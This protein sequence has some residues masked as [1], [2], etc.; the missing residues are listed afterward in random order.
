MKKIA[1]VLF[2]L[3][4]MVSIFLFSSCEYKVPKGPVFIE[5]INYQYLVIK[6]VNLDKKNSDNP[7]AI[8]LEN[9][10]DHYNE[11]YFW[12]KKDSSGYK[13][14]TLSW[15]N[16]HVLSENF[17]YIILDTIHNNIN[18]PR[19]FKS[20]NTEAIFFHNSL[21]KAYINPGKIFKMTFYLKYY[22]DTWG[23]FLTK[24]DQGLLIKYNPKNKTIEKITAPTLKI[25]KFDWIPVFLLLLFIMISVLINIKKKYHLWI[26]IKTLLFTAIFIGIGYPI[27]L[28]NIFEPIISIIIF[29]GCL[30]CLGPLIFRIKFHRQ[31]Q[32]AILNTII[33]GLVLWALTGQFTV[34]VISMSLISLAFFIPK[35]IKKL[36]TSFYTKKIKK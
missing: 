21:T 11:N 35:F 36:T 19:I 1:N 24:Y 29:A 28:I 9:R 22:Y 34:L 12:I 5:S 3:L 32:Y 7:Q 18:S 2:G 30:A 23:I 8:F 20:R 31:Y 14:I 17:A 10:S 4:F 26:L 16:E 27:Y 6:Q 25:T 13:Q 33:G 15:K